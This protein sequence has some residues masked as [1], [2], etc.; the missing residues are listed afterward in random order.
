MRMS[1]FKGADKMKM[2]VKF[3]QE[4][5]LKDLISGKLYMN[6]IKYFIDLEK[7]MAI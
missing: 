7:N 1:E 5:H 3:V 2:Y 4:K 6:N